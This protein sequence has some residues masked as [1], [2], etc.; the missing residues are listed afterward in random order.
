M[1]RSGRNLR[2]LL[3]ALLAVIVLGVGTLVWFGAWYYPALGL[4][5]VPKDGYRRAMDIAVRGMTASE[6]LAFQDW[7]FRKFRQVERGGEAYAWGA[8][9]CRARDGSTSF[10]WVYLEW[11][12]KRGQW[13]RNFSE[14]L[15][16]PDDEIYFTRTSP[17]QF[18]RARLALSKI[19]GQL[20][21]HVREARA[22]G[23]N[24]Q[25]LPSSGL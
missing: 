11:S 18:G 25:D 5:G 3:Y 16:T 2:R 24:P 23:R 13:L 12:K 1:N 4:T 22:F 17:G 6:G 8:A 19:L 14:E 7:D 10:Y 20:A 9:R 15:A 21:A